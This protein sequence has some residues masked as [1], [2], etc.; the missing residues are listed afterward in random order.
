MAI[1][2]EAYGGLPPPSERQRQQTDARQDRWMYELEHAMLQSAKKPA[3]SQDGRAPAAVQDDTP[4]PK[5][6][7]RQDDQREPAEAA[8]AMA[9]APAAK[10]QVNA[11]ES[12]AT[13]VAAAV[14]AGQGAGAAAQEQ[15][16]APSRVAAAASAPV[17]AAAM[18]ATALPGSG[19][20]PSASPLA[21]MTS[22]LAAAPGASHS[23]TAGAVMGAD[24]A[25]D[26]AIPAAPGA[27]WL[28]RAAEAD[29][30]LLA[31]P[32][33]AET[34]P[35]TPEPAPATASDEPYAAR[36]LHVYRDAD[37][38]QAWLRDASLGQMQAQQLA[39]AMAGELG[40]AGAPLTALTVNGRRQVLPG[41]PAVDASQDEFTA[42]ARTDA[43]A[44]PYTL[45]QNGAI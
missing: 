42:E 27:G 21:A 37:G 30:A 33:D 5:R 34:P 13:P 6:Q 14:T 24:S 4:L 28:S 38:V 1:N 45:Y 15:S 20:A 39:R 8:A 11:P 9:S 36:L 26:N 43:P 12:A 22:A 32:E 10:A 16:A 31:A 17:P 23:L 2:V 41:A 44:S 19:A 25:A 29:G 3:P 40:S 18:L 7:S 35:A